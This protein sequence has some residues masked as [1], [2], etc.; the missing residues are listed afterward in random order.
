[1]GTIPLTVD[2]F[3]YYY[4]PSEISHSVGFYQF[5]TKGFSCRLVKSPPSSNRRWKM[6]FLFVLGF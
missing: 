3:L 4:K 2:E 6:E 1:M 5:S